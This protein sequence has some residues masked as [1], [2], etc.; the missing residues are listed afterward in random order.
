MA[1]FD[2]GAYLGVCVHVEHVPN[3]SDVMISAFFGLQGTLAL[4]GGTRGRTLL[5]TGV[6]IADSMAALNVAEEVWG[7]TQ[8]NDG[9][10]HTLVDDR[11]RVFENL[12][13]VGS[14][15]PSAEGPKA[16]ATGWLLP[17]RIS[18]QGLT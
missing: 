6:L 4:S 14:F 16:T 10:V 18:F 9:N 17:F 5:V 8:F 15:Q 13:Y 11:G 2:G 12:L 1:T 7:G 3:A